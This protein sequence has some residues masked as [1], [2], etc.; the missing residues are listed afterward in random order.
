MNNPLKPRYTPALRRLHWLM[1][2]LIVAAYLLIEQRGVFP[3]GSAER[4]AMVQGHFWVGITVFV[5]ALSLFARLV[6]LRKRV[7]HD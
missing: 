7:A 1:A 4:A 6:L 2:I 3:R 5:L